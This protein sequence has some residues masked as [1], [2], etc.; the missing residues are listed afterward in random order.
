MTVDGSS[1]PEA[2]EAPPVADDAS[3]E[4]AIIAAPELVAD[5]LVEYLKGWYQ[6]IRSGDSGVVPVV[7]ALLAIVIFF[8]AKTSLY[9][10]PGNIV[11]L[12]NQAV[13]FIL[14]ALA[15]VFVLLLGELD[16][17]ISF[18]AGIGAGLMAA[19]VAPPYDF[20]WWCC[21][22]IGVAVTTAIG[23]IQ[24]LL[25]TK[26]R[27]P[28]FIVTLA[29]YIGLQGV[30]IAMFDSFKSAVGGVLS[31]SNP[32]ILDI[33]GYS[34]SPMASW[35]TMVALV[36]VWGGYTIQR[37]TRRR[38]A[39]LVVPPPSLTYAKVGFAAAAGVV[40]VLICN[41]NRGTA[42]GTKVSGVP[43]SIPVLLAIFV[44]TSLLLARTRFGRYVY[45]I[46][47]NAEAAR[48]AG[49]NVQLVRLAC[50]GLAG[51]M[52]GLAG[53]M[54]LSQLGSISTD[55]DPSYV[56]YAVAGAVIGGTSLFGGR[57]KPLHAV[58]GGLVIAAVYNGI[59]LINLG[60]AANYMVVGVVLIVATTV[61]SLAR[62]RSASTR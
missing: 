11:N 14:F 29:G 18:N 42:G 40:L 54:L 7:I 56:L 2:A 34:M 31:V 39:G 10:S 17:S 41:S 61:D 45:A 4:A 6:R 9:L 24:G 60:T 16:L 57:G 33:V 48:R 32:V 21:V 37:E 19:Y 13:V 1:T 12:F 36:V 49:I 51:L 43:W 3:N 26:L 27:L 15:E 47:G 53:L 44:L 35:I 58:L 28:A 50:F 8:E 52:A 62:G 25:I 46:G 30:M 5:T 20:P 55:L 22:L 59:F 38:A 23:L